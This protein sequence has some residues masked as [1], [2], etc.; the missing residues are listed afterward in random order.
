MAASRWL[1]HARCR[2]LIDACGQIHEACPAHLFGH[3]LGIREGHGLGFSVAGELST[4][5]LNERAAL[6]STAPMPPNWFRKCSPAEVAA[7]LGM[8]IGSVYAAKSRVLDHA[9]GLQPD[10]GHDGELGGLA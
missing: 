6:G 4:A 8:N 1:R 2:F 7:E 10:S 5:V 9:V 3:I